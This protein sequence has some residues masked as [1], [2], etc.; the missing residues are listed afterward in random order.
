LSL[1]KRT[2]LLMSLLLAGACLADAEEPVEGVVI[3]GS[4]IEGSNTSGTLPVTFL[5]ADR[6]AALGDV[7]G[8]DLMRAIPQMGNVTFNATND[9]QTSNAARGDVASIDLRGSGLSDTLVLVNGR[10]VVEHPTSQSRGGVPLISYNAQALPTAGVERVEILRQGAAAIYGADAVAGVVNVVTKVN[11]D[12][13]SADL[14]YGLAEGTHR[15]ETTADIVAGRGFDERRGNLSVMLTAYHRETQLPS[16]QVYTATQD[17][18]SFFTGIPEY[19]SSSAPDGRGNQSSFPALVARRIT[20]APVSSAVLQR[21]VPLTSTAGSFHVKPDTLSGCVAQL[22]TDLCIGRGSVPYSSTAN[23]LRYDAR[24]RDAVTI[25]PEIDRLNVLLNG[26]YEFSDALTAYTEVS[27]YGAR[28]LGRTTQP[29]ALVPIGV[30]ASN[31]YNPLGPTTFADGTPNPN[32]LPSLTNVP[33]SGLPVSFATYRFNDLGPARVE[34]TSF[35]DRFLIGARGRIG[36]YQ[37]DSAMLYG[38]GQ[39]RD[40]SD[41][42]DSVLLARQLALSTPDAY[43]PFNGG[44]LDGSGGTDCSPSSQ[45]ALDAIRVRLRRE[46]TSRLFN[47]DLRFSRPDLLQLPAGPLSVAFGIEGRRESHL[48]ERD[49]RI[50]GSTPFTDPV[51]GTVSLSSAT[52]V[53]TTPTTSGSRNVGAFFGETAI[54][55]AQTVNVQLAGRVEH[56]SDFGTVAKPR[57]A[58]RWDVVSGVRLRASWEQGFKAPNLETMASHTYARAQTVTD[59]YR[60]EAALNNGRISTFNA[61]NENFGIS[62][63]ESGNPQLRPETS[64]SYNVG[65]VL[66]P[67][68]F[69]DAWGRLLLSVDRWR[70]RQN[71]IVGVV[72]FDTISVQDYLDRANGGTGIADFV[73][74]AVTAD[75]V[76]FY[77][78]SGLQPVGAPIVANDRFMNLQPKTIA[79]VDVSLTWRKMTSAFGTFG[80]GLDATR[81]DHYSQPPSPE[82]QVLVDA[83][84]AGV[85]NPATPVDIL[86]NQLQVRGNPKWKATATFTWTGRNLQLGSAVIYTG[87]TRDTDFLSSTGVPWPVSSLTTVNLHGQYT[88]GRYRIKLGGRNVLDQSPPLQSDGFNGALYVPYGRYIYFSLGASF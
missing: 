2:P 62:Y 88:L 43:N 38:E 31:Y 81:L 65:L 5:D 20:G 73:R 57:V 56:Y 22:G 45:S 55:L 12:G 26:H 4:R 9:Q 63:T 59:W 83:R 67:E 68:F 49:P 8:D 64:H 47:A 39:V 74:S 3:V 21:G 30:P 50:N 36:G 79:G 14:R 25:A 77:A 18:R 86:G 60:C 48:D 40:V 78:G 28:S 15:K 52:G 70:L 24:A 75:D 66:G 27:Y 32:R 80:A 44:C 42:I 53:N 41:G 35:Q 37:Y 17:L 16:D 6:I 11:V 46:S 7:S 13:V 69:P 76:A 51:L 1:V 23:V 58:L 85:I 72:G 82:L 33:A 84:A 19:G 29:T 10:R 71:S 34:V 61:C 54:P 87:T